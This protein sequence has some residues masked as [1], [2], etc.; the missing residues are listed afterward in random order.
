MKERIN[1]SGPRLIPNC[2]LGDYGK[3]SNCAYDGHRNPNCNGCGW[4]LFE[5]GKRRVLIKENGLQPI[6]D[7]QREWLKRYWGAR[8]DGEIRGLRV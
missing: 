2:T 1:M 4:D 7:N 3:D 5:I 6:S 8:A